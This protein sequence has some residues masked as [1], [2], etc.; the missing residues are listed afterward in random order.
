[1]RLRDSA[2]LVKGGKKKEKNRHLEQNALRKQAATVSLQKE[3]KKNGERRRDA[4][5]DATYYFFRPSPKK[6][7]R[8]SSSVTPCFC[9]VKSK[10][11]RGEEKKSKKTRYEGQFMG[12]IASGSSCTNGSTTSRTATLRRKRGEEEECQR[13][14]RTSAVL[15]S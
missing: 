15:Q 3:R 7:K 10:R 5:L 11:E 1:V 12:V 4:G 14:F 2:A 9:T 8:G 6:R 13:K